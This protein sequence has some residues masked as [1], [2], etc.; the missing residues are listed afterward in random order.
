MGTVKSKIEIEVERIVN[1]M[2]KQR[3]KKLMGRDHGVGESVE[4][5]NVLVQSVWGMLDPAMFM[6]VFDTVEGEIYTGSLS[7]LGA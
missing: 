1:E 6:G 7:R 5:M 4:W 3:G 2:G